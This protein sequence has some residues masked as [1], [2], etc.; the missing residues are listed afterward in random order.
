VF[1]DPGCPACLSVSRQV[2]ELRRL[3]G[4][5][6]RIVYKFF[7]TGKGSGSMDAALFGQMAHKK[8]LFWVFH[9]RLVEAGK[10]DTDMYSSLL[11]KIGIPLAEQR[12]MLKAE[13]EFLVR[14]VDAHVADARALG[15]DTA[16][17][18]YVNAY[19]LG[20]ERLPLDGLSG[21]VQR[22]LD[23]KSILQPSGG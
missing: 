3:H 20:Q 22:L 10:A 9:D 15:L 16:P 8:G 21:Y 17:V 14:R 1:N 19:R 4:D 11:E 23:G 12:E 6:V 2:L 18:V 7:P 13:S 5:K